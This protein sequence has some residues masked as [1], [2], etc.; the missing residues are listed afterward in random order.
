MNRQVRE[1]LVGV[2]FE[3]VAS[4]PEAFGDWIRKEIPRW[5]NVIRETGARA[6]D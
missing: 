2:E 1:K 4:T 5:G 6:T 3:L